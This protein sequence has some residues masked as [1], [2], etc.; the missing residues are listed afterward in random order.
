MTDYFSYLAILAV[1]VSMG[2]AFAVWLKSR[3]TSTKAEL[4]YALAA[5]AKL[6]ARMPGAADHLALAQEQV[7]AEA[8]AQQNLVRALS[9][10]AGV[11]PAV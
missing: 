1:G 9:G 6:V 7:Q 5:E 4:L 8:L 10:V 2:A 3:K 11:P